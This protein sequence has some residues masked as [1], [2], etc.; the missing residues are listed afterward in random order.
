MKWVWLIRYILYTVPYKLS[1]CIYYT[2]T[3][4]SIGWTV[5]VLRKLLTAK[6]GD[7]SLAMSRLSD[8][9]KQSL[10]G[11]EM[12]EYVHAHYECC[13]GDTPPHVCIEFKG[14]NP[15]QWLNVIL[16]PRHKTIAR[17]QVAQCQ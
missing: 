5:S 13:Y 2:F 17:I 9:D 1:P 11:S 3:F 14:Q 12:H 6:R 16:F 8:L 7:K 10:Y 15:A 4:S